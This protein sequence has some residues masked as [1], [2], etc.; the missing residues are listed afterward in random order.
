MLIFTLVGESGLL[1]FMIRPHSWKV[2]K[3]IKEKTFSCQYRYCDGG[4]GAGLRVVGNSMV[5][6]RE[7]FSE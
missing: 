3:I 4:R 6:N 7:F 2:L 1:R 5:I